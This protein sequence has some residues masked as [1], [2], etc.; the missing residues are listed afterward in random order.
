MVCV[1][2]R[3][4]FKCIGEKCK[5]STGRISEGVG[6]VLK[7]NGHLYHCRP[8]WAEP[9]ISQSKYQ[10]GFWGGIFWGKKSQTCMIPVYITTVLYDVTKWLI[11]CL[12]GLQVT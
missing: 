5:N 12:V 10:A 2:I 7:G 11:V 3:V 6:R 4:Y 8:V 1:I 9:Q